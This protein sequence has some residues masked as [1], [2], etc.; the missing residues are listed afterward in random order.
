MVKHRTS[1]EFPVDVWKRLCDTV[2]P[3]KRGRSEKDI[4]SGNCA[5][6][7][8]ISK[9]Y[10]IINILDFYVIYIFPFK[11]TLGSISPISKDIQIIFVFC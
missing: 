10:K 3:R 9:Y 2:P 8:I 1:L 11:Y 7:V 5:Y 4:Y 6:P